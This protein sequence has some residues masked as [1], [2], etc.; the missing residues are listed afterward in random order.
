MDNL[1]VVAYGE[2]TWSIGAECG[3]STASMIAGKK[4]QSAWSFEYPG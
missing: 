3:S 1:L 2:F 4:S